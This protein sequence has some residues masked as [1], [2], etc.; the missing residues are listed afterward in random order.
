[1]AGQEL[2]L[3]V[4]GDRRAAVVVPE[5]RAEP[6]QPGR[7]TITIHVP[8]PIALYAEH[9]AKVAGL[10]VEDV[11]LNLIA[12]GLDSRLVERTSVKDTQTCPDDRPHQRGTI[13]IRHCAR[14]G[15]RMP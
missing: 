11:L 2:V 10:S 3:S 14:C 13:N 6:P 4:P 5:L 9:E 1:M 12:D 8:Q 15:A 7:R